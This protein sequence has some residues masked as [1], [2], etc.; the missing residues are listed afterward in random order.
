MR[1][2]KRIRRAMVRLVPIRRAVQQL[3][4]TEQP[5]TIQSSLWVLERGLKDLQVR[6][7]RTRPV[8]NYSK[9]NS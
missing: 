4:I 9:T 2:R 1:I 5:R 3:V 8:M 6:M 7:G